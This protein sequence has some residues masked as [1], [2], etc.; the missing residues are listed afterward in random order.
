MKRI[1][2]PA[3][4][5]M[6]LK[7]LALA[8]LCMAVELWPPHAAADDLPPP[9]S[10]ISMP[11]TTLYLEPVVN[12]RQT[13]KV[14][15][16]TYRGG[17]YYLTPQQLSDAGLPVAD[18]QAK[19]I[20]VDQLDKIDVTYSGET[21]QLL[22]SVP[23]DWL[24]KQTLGDANPEQRLP[25]QSSLG[26]LLNYDAYVSQS[27]GR[28]NP[29]YFSAWSEQRLFDGFGVIANTGIFRSSFNGE[30][31]AQ[32]NNRYIRYDSSWR[33]SDDD[34]MLSYTTGD[35]TTGSLPWTS[36]VRI[37][38]LQVARNFATR[39]DLITYPLPQ[40]SGQAAVPSSVDLYINS[41]KN[42]S[43][44]VNPGPFTLNTV[45]Y[46]NGAGQATVVTT[47][48]LGRQIST[49]VPFYVASSLLQ[50][51]LSDFSLSAGALRQNYGYRS[52]DYG[53][54]VASGS[55]RYGVTDWLTLEGLR[56]AQ[57]SWRSPAPARACA[58]GS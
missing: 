51:G 58:W 44:S 6:Q 45:P 4:R 53:Q 15:P 16:V 41:Y 47:D 33:Y 26:F 39:P 22:I 31:A 38:G 5:G 46:I 9:P 37:G 25:A 49:T 21:Q 17:H 23:N 10:T 12:G 29:G 36:S 27:G 2:S 3:T 34:T 57:L 52:A 19:E 32:Q 56:K 14:V 7:P 24:P 43:V 40:F 55:G 20:A 8:V 50:A 1:S 28:G 13:G 18:K 30:T 42:T 11:D 35:L 54:W 48:A